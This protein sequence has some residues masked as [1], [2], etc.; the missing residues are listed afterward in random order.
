MWKNHHCLC[1]TTWIFVL[2]IAYILYKLSCAQEIPH[3]E[4]VLLCLISINIGFSMLFWYD[5]VQNSDIHIYDAFFAKLSLVT[6][7]FYFFSRYNSHVD[8]VIFLM[9]L[10]GI[11]VS[12]YYSNHFSSTEWCCYNHI[13]SHGLMHMFCGLG[14]VYVL[15]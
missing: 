4:Y 1:V 10:V 9:I 3:F 13:Q 7:I 14:C 12:A 15:V 8:V 2:P 6:F 5:P 11:A